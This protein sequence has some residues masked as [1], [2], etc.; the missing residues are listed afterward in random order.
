MTDA[1]I[2]LAKTPLPLWAREA[3]LR[4]ADASSRSMPRSEQPRDWILCFTGV[5][6]APA[7]PA[8][9]TLDLNERRTE[10]PA[11]Q[12]VTELSVSGMTCSNCARHVTGAIQN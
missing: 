11:N 8:E 10:R 6:W 12:A 5:C 2:R 4:A 7:M 1:G 3:G 9:P